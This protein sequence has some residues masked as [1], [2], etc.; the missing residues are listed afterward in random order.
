MDHGRVRS[1]DLKVAIYEPFKCSTETQS[2]A[3]LQPMLCQCQGQDTL[4]HATDL[5]ITCQ[6]VHLAVT[7]CG[8]HTQQGYARYEDVTQPHQG[9]IVQALTTVLPIAC[10]FKHCSFLESELMSTQYYE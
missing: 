10:D 7:L 9:R 2:G 4:P 5:L 1:E 6:E 3:L 8:W